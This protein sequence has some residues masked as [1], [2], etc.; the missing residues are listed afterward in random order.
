MAETLTAH[1]PVEQQALDALVQGRNGDPFSLL[2]RHPSKGGAVI[3]A[4]MPGAL[5]VCVLSRKTGETLGEL[6]RIHNAGV[7][8][9]PIAR[10]EPYRL[11]IQWSEAVQETEDPYSFGLL[12]SDED[13]H[14]FSA[15]THPDPAN[16]LGA[17]PRTVDGVP[18]VRFAVWAPNARRVSVVGDFNA[19]DGRRHPMR[20]RHSAGI[21]ELFI[22][23]LG[24]GE[25]YKYEIVGPDM[26]VLPLKADPFARA[27]EMPPATASIVADV[28]PFPWTDD[29][30]M[31]G[32]A[33]RQRPDAPISVYEVHAG[34][35]FRDGDHKSP[36]WDALAERLVPY[37]ERM[38]F[39]HIELM[40]V[41]E[42]PFG[43]SWGYQPLSQ[44][45]PTARMGEPAGFAR[46]VDRF[47]EA[48]IGVL[49]DW[50]PGHFPNDAHGL[51]RFDGTAL[52]E[53]EDPREGF[54]P[55]W[56]SMIYNFGRNEVVNFLIGSALFWLERFHVDGLRVDAVASML[57]RDYS[58]KA[59]EWIPN[60]HGGRETSSRSR[61]CAISTGP[62]ANAAPARSCSRRNPPHGPASPTTPSM[63]ASASPT[64]GTWAGCTTR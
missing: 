8:A 17:S 1:L 13:L 40:P 42:H 51:V 64:N 52:Y 35:W 20:L 19:W 58:R 43:G 44:Y 30:W 2:G 57:Y 3:R 39:T 7:F 34:S 47:H 53:H 33:A 5:A 23:R 56:H 41:M 12:L 59:G 38:G 4:F 46:F 28:S 9:G 37:V 18:G 45:A 54:H 15:G 21:W 50:V 25:R 60:I 24:I 31:A 29:E 14:T 36:T 55:D 26:S 11:R 62:S 22:P 27:T 6:P 49:L 10:D 32:R 48:G 63:A 61:F 16:S